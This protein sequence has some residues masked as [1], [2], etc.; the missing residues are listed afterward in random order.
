MPKND[1]SADQMLL[2]PP[3]LLM[4]T[5]KLATWEVRVHTPIFSQHLCPEYSAAPGQEDA[6]RPLPAGAPGGSHG[7]RWT[8][9][10]KTP[11]CG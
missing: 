9:A 6:T 3:L 2:L 1:D 5:T 11:P 7:G 4:K 8:K 10:T